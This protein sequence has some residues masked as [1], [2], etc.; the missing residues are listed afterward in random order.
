[1]QDFGRYPRM[2]TFVQEY[3]QAL[4]TQNDGR[5]AVKNFVGR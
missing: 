1:M 3:I 2:R 5:Q 4:S